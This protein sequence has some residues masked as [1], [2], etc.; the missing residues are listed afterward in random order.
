MIKNAFVNIWNKPVGAVAWNEETQTGN[1]E[2]APDFLKGN[3]D[4][5]PIKMPLA[6]AKGR[7]F[8]FPENRGS[9]TFKGLPGLLADTLPDRYGNALINAWLTKK[10]RAPDSMN[11]VEMLCFIGKRGMGALEFEP[12]EPKGGETAT[13]IEID[14][15]VSIAEEILSGRKQFTTK[16]SKE[17]EKGLMDILKIGT[18][19]GGARAKAVIAYN[20]K[21][22]E[23]R[24]GQTEAPRGFSHWLIKLDGIKD[25]Q[26]GTSQGYGRVELAYHR[27]AVDCGIE[28]TECQLY[29]EHG[30]AH[31]MTR[32]FDRLPGKVKLHVQSFCALMHYDYN[33]ILSYSYE[34]L[35]Q[36]M[37][38]LRL[39]YPEAEQMFRRM[40][41]NVMARNCDDHTKNFSFEMDATGEWKLTPAY[42]LCHAYRPGS[43][44]VSRQSL[45]VNGKRENIN[46]KDLLEVANQIS[47][48]R[49][50][51]IIDQISGILKKW[52]L[53][54]EQTKVESKLRDAIKK[55]LISL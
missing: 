43:A 46:R 33:D 23:V 32:R 12:V 31:F 22:K 47:L 28:M 26:L 3:L 11:P 6:S 18:S 35:F 4:L 20:P 16:L 38:V 51:A 10:G 15:L 37:R 27:M 24:S 9:I 53:Y 48:K 1:F 21:T 50:E 17:E 45:S 36:T 2:F 14:S 5:A 44:W 52:N 25:N 55:T 30:R 41:F 34:Q 40:V 7:I 8:S 19:A 54:A 39:T 29:E 42:D 13:K 49:G